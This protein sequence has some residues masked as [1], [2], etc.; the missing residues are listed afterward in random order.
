MNTM[1]SKHFS[2]EEFEC[3][4]GCGF[5]GVD[6]ILLEVLEKTRDYFNRPIRLT[7]GNRCDAHNKEVGG[8]DG[9][10]HKKCMAIDFAV[11]GVEQDA[12]AD[13][14]EERYPDTF[15]I[16]RYIGRTHLDIRSAKARWDKR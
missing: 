5:G 12:V 13:Y 6:T 2:R 11:I 14:L 1:V 4:C 9:S 3:Q 10:F 7:S 8:A 16:G 15:G